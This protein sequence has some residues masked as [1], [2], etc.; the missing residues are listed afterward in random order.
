MRYYVDLLTMNFFPD[1]LRK[2]KTQMFRIRPLIALSHHRDSLL[3][4]FVSQESTVNEASNKFG[5]P[6]CDQDAEQILIFP[7]TYKLRYLNNNTSQTAGSQRANNN[8]LA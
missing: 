5:L 7:V 8:W 2:S 4:S 6:D 3:V 1:C